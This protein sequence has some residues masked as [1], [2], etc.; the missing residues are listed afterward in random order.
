MKRNIKGDFQIYKFIFK[1]YNTKIKKRYR[2]LIN[3]PILGNLVHFRH[4]SPEVIRKID[5]LIDFA[6]FTGNICVGALWPTTL[7]KRD[8]NTGVFL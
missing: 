2:V 7:L 8:S 5:V 6:K 4:S 1:N 3:Y